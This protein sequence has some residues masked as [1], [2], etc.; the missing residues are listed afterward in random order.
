MINSLLT[1][2][3]PNPY[4]ICIPQ[5]NIC[6]NYKPNSIGEH[7][8]FIPGM[9]MYMATS[10]TYYECIITTGCDIH[11]YSVIPGI[12]HTSV[13]IGVDYPYSA[14]TKFFDD[15]DD[16]FKYIMSNKNHDFSNE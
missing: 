6:I 4:G 16:A 11:Y 8:K 3:G 15:Q 10:D 1:P 7:Y 5:N 2:T 13:L 9:L 12:E 14:D